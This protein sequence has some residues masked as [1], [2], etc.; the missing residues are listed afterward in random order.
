MTKWTVEQISDAAE[1]AC[2][3]VTEAG[4]WLRMLSTSIDDACF[5]AVDEDSGEEYCIDFSEL[6]D[7]EDP[8]FE[9]LV[10]TQIVSEN[11]VKAAYPGGVCPDCGTDIPDDVADGDSCE[12]CDHTF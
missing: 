7:V 6:L 8:H 11:A 12:N 10:K 4:L 9:H 3:Y 1:G 5:W 2:F